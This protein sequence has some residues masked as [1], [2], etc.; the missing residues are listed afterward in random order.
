MDY[1]GKKA[2]TMDGKLIVPTSA[3]PGVISIVHNEIGHRGVNNT[4]DEVKKRFKGHALQNRTQEVVESC[5]ACWE[6]TRE[7]PTNKAHQHIPVSSSA[8]NQTLW[9]DTMGPLKDAHQGD[10]PTPYVL[11]MMDGFS[12]YAK[13]VALPDHKAPTVAAA[14]L[15][16]SLIH[17]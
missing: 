6:K 16:L 2:L 4:L 14:V 7:V 13:A 3:L 10:K 15:N 8:V 17:I 5:T 12:R 1:Q 9:L 11:T